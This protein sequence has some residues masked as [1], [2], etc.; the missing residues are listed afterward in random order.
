LD[1][2][3][4]SKIEKNRRDYILVSSWY[5]GKKLNTLRYYDNLKDAKKYLKKEESGDLATALED[6]EFNRLQQA[7]EGVKGVY[8]G[9]DE[10]Y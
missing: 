3:A 10:S 4:Y 9:V 5:G 2:G 1:D 6:G 8:I 7:F